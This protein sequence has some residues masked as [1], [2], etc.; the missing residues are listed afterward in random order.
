MTVDERERTWN[1]MFEES[2]A[3][4][5]TEP[6][7]PDSKS[8]IPPEAQWSKT[9]ASQSI[10]MTH[11]C[12]QRYWEWVSFIRFFLG[13]GGKINLQL[14]FSSYINT[15]NFQFQP[16][17]LQAQVSAA[18]LTFHSRRPHVML[19]SQMNRTYKI[20]EIDSAWSFNNRLCVWLEC[21]PRHRALFRSDKYEYS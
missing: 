14:N 11:K 20:R 16:I 13:G 17:P 4:A 12:I 2:M 3:A 8:I 7:G 10:T 1:P 21:L 9:S 19:Y 5:E 15:L 18:I 6:P